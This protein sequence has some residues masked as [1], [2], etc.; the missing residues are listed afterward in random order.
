MDEFLFMC[1]E[2][3]KI[4]NSKIVHL[5]HNKHEVMWWLATIE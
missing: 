3:L 5:Y 4:P 2:F 1:S